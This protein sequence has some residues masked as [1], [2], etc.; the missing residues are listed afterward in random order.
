MFKMTRKW[1]EQCGLRGGTARR[2]TVRVYWRL[3]SPK[4]QSADLTHRENLERN[5]KVDTPN[6]VWL[7]ARWSAGQIWAKLVEKFSFWVWT[8]LQR[9]LKVWFWCVIIWFIV[10]RLN[11][12]ESTMNP[13]KNLIK[14]G[15]NAAFYTPRSHSAEPWRRWTSLTLWRIWKQ[16][17]LR[18][19]NGTCVRAASKCLAWR[20]QKGGRRWMWWC[21]PTASLELWQRPEGF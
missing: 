5:T 12:Q 8:N 14:W 3:V 10:Y 4:V 13:F 19:S 20:K 17:S 1:P 7:S 2:D 6:P 15:L 9:L 11:C 21:R 18:L 16:R